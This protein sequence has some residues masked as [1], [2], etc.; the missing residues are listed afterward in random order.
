MSSQREDIAA[1]LTKSKEKLFYGWVIIFIT[2]FTSIALSGSRFSF[3]VFFKPL[4]AE[5]DLSRAE[6]S[7]LFSV[8]MIFGAVCTMVGGWALDKYG[9][10][11]VLASMGLFTGLGLVLT[12]YM[13]SPW[14]LFLSYSLLLAMGTGA[15]FTVLNSTVS[16]WFDKKRG[17]ALGI[18]GAGVG[19]G[20]IVYAPFAAF[21]VSNIDWRMSFIVI[22]V[23]IWLLVTIFSRFMRKDPDAIGALPDGAK[24][25]KIP[26]EGK[27]EKDDLQKFGM[28]YPRR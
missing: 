15:S 5:F 9:P 8:Y 19:L 26:I 28:S 16:R 7:S 2:L 25:E 20:Q 12:S 11:I 10:R 24:P 22:G 4:A 27:S 18:S 6:T 13:N 1:I 14:Q 23:I 17:L 3:G 21:L